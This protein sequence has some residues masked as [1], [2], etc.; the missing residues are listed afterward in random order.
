MVFSRLSYKYQEQII[1][2]LSRYL[3]RAVES[4][5]ELEYGGDVATLLKR[6]WS[7]KPNRDL[8]PAFARLLLSGV[9]FLHAARPTESILNDISQS[10]PNPNLRL[11]VR[12]TTRSLLDN[13]TPSR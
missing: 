10:E 8:P 2:A 11:H 5:A 7:D 6:I 9:R 3:A 4:R 13:D 1:A 12:D